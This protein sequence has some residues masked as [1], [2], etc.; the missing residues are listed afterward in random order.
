MVMFPSA[1]LMGAA[2]PVGVKLWAGDSDQTATARLGVFYAL[3]VCGGIAGS[4]AAGFFLLPQA[5]S[6]TSLLGVAAAILLSGVALV[7]VAPLTRGRRAALAG[8]GVILYAT[9]AATLVDPMR[10][11]IAQRFPGE[12]I[13]WIE[14][15]VQSTVSVNQ[16]GRFKMETMDGIHQASDTSSLSFFHHLLGQL[17][18]AIHPNPRD[19]LVV[20]LGGGATAGAIGLHTGVRV[21]VVE[22]SPAVVH[23]ANF[24]SKVNYD[25]LNRPNV[26]LRVDDGRNHLLL[27]KW[28]YD[29]ITADIILPIHAGSTNVYSRE[30]FQ[31]CRN[32][33]NPGGLV[34]QWVSGTEAE[35]KIIMRTFLSVFPDATLWA[36]GNVLIGSTK[37]L[38]MS[39]GDFEWKMGVPERA[40]G[41]R[42][43]NIT[44]FEELVNLY[45]A[46][47]QQL[48]RYVGDGPILT[49]DRPLAEYFLS[50]PRDRQPDRSGLTRDLSEIVVP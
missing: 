45:T 30:Y 48:A 19:A 39:R 26:N 20:G 36:D 3:N 38:R 34:A 4:L 46:G 21:D 11:F 15:G 37:P 2:F 8:A 40:G 5:G 43:V 31:A 16:F 47:P 28:K 35:Y 10:A 7:A 18:M 25:V 49:D 12:S 33:L 22:L 1:L 32:A 14:E 41:F 42:D 24:F 17:P 9:A 13:I 50:L 6:R 29:V 27:T 23:A 44:K